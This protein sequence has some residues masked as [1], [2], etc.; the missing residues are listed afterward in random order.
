M[1]EKVTVPRSLLPPHLR[2]GTAHR[3]LT[4]L[5]SVLDC[6]GIFGNM[7]SRGF[8]VGAIVETGGKQYKVSPGEIVRVEKLRTRGDSL[9]FDKVLAV[10]DNGA[11]SGQPLS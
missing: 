1:G 8:H 7:V 4:C 10:S 6:N 2:Q 11:E 5:S 9:V 3:F